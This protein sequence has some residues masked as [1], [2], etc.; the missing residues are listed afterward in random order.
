MLDQES[1]HRDLLTKLLEPDPPEI[2]SDDV[3][4]REL[5][6]VMLLHALSSGSI[7]KFPP[8]RSEAGAFR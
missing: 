8:S 3:V 6:A 1:V 7:S 5:H 4:R 2:E